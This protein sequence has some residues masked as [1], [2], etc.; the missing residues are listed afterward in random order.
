MANKIEAST[1]AVNG[2]S[3]L[4]RMVCRLTLR[5]KPTMAAAS[6][7]VVIKLI[8]SIDKNKIVDVSFKK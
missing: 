7:N 4:S 2:R 5:P 8:L 6:K 3:A 1:I